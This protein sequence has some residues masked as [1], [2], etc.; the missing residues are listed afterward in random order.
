METQICAVCLL[1]SSFSMRSAF[2]RDIGRPEYSL[3]TVV[4]IKKIR[5]IKIIGGEPLIMKKQY[6]MLDAIIETGHADRIH[7]KYQTNL[8]ETKAGKHNL[9]SY[10]PKFHQ[11]AVVASVDGIG[12]TIEY[13]R[14]RTDWNKVVKNI[15]LC[16]QYDN[17]VV[18]FNALV[19]FLSV[20][21]FYEVN[22]NYR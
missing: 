17:A 1:D 14:R 18:D 6:K 20:L 16:N 3:N 15:E 10:I 19:S 8:T 12:K 9:L 11:V 21:R 13:M 22:Q 7:L 2:G 5:S 4:T